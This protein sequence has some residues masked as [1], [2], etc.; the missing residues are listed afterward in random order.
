[1][2]KAACHHDFLCGFM[3]PIFHHAL[4]WVLTGDVDWTALAAMIAGDTA[5]ILIVLGLAKRL[6]DLAERRGALAPIVR[7]WMP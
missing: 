1:M 7:R 2:E 4:M 5:G 6:F 3:G